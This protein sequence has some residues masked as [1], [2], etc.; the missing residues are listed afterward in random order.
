[1]P[2]SDTQTAPGKW[3]LLTARCWA[4]N[5][6]ISSSTARGWTRFASSAASLSARQNDLICRHRLSRLNLPSVYQFGGYLRAAVAPRASAAG[7]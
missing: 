6:P 2:L 7:L 5:A 4:L 3:T 1:M